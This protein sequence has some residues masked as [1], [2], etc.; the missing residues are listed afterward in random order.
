MVAGSHTLPTGLPSPQP[1]PG[2]EGGTEA[3]ISDG[4][5]G[6]KPTE[7]PP[8]QGRGTPLAAGRLLPH[9]R[10]PHPL[11]TPTPALHYLPICWASS[12]ALSQVPREEFSLA[13]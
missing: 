3:E 4:G 8:P 10:G 5:V 12:L 9:R 11:A 1:V 6:V 7:G 2:T 13:M